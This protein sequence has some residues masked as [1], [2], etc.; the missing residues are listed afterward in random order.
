MA[1]ILVGVSQQCSLGQIPGADGRPILTNQLQDQLV[2]GHRLVVIQSR[3]HAIQQ[4][5][6]EV[7]QV[8]FTHAAQEFDNRILEVG[9]GQIA[10][11]LSR[12]ARKDGIAVVGQGAIEV[13]SNL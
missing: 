7:L 9:A 8:L 6:E 12:A 2:T 11:I 13:Q 5:V 3:G 4:G 1:P 10:G